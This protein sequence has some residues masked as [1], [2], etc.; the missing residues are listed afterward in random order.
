MFKVKEN[1]FSDKRHRLLITLILFSHSI[2][3]GLGER[4]YK[5][6]EKICSE[7]WNSPETQHLQALLSSSVRI[8]FVK[9]ELAALKSTAINAIPRLVD[10]HISKVLLEK[11]EKKKIVASLCKLIRRRIIGRKGG[12]YDLFIAQTFL[13]ILL[14]TD[15]SQLLT[16]VLQ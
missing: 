16:F 14:F 4:M 8:Q 9:E 15:S 13:F 2:G 12:K 5:E 1:R 6:L 10:D 11:F 3:V 7:R